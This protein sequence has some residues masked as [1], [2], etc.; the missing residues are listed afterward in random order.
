MNCTLAQVMVHISIFIA[1]FVFHKLTIYIS[2]AAFNGSNLANEGSI[3][4][5]ETVAGDVVL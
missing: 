1:S 3:V 5:V 4:H 2:W